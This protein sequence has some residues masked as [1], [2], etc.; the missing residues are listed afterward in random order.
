MFPVLFRLG[1]LSIHTYG[2]LIVLG[3]LVGVYLIRKKAINENLNPD[4][5]TDIAFWAL[6]MGLLGGRILFIITLWKEFARDPLEMLRFWNGGLVYYGGLIG[7]ALTFWYLAK[8]Y[9]LNVL[10]V[11]DIATPSLAIAHF[12]GRL[13]CFV[14]GCCFGKE[15]DP[16]FPLAVVFK[17]PESIAPVNIPLHPAQLYDAANAMI[18]FIA[19]SLF[20]PYHKFRGQVLAI[21]LM[22][23]AVGRSI[24]E[25]YRGDLVRGF[26]IENVLSTS[27][28]ISIFVFVAGLA[29]YFFGQKYFPIQK[30]ERK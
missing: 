28:F 12:F 22:I 16:N 21:Y 18:I 20:Y 25:Q 27:Q 19:L 11:M 14:A 30:A 24:V 6:L 3:F 26:V 4:Q 7:G 9:R 17:S 13:G 5:L 23:Y 10:Q 8:R 2:A 29:L 1:P 15:C